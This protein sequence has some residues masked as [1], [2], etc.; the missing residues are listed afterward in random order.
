[1]RIVIISRWFAERMGY[2]E[3]C[4]PKALAAQGCDVHLV[5]ANVKPYFN[6][7]KYQEIYQRFLGDAIVPPDTRFLDGYTLY[8]QEHNVW[9]G[10]VGIKGLI[11]SL[12]SLR[13]HIV[14]TFDA[15]EYSTHKAALV[16][17]ISGYK[18]FLGS[19]LH[20]SVLPPAFLAQKQKLP[21]KRQI[22]S[23]T[24]GSILNAATERCYA[25]SA[26]A[27]DIV[28]AFSGLAPQKIEISPLGVDTDTF[29]PAETAE[30]K[31]LRASMRERFKFSDSEI[32]CIYTGRFSHDKDPLCLAKAINI[33]SGQGY[34]F[35][36]LFIGDGSQT[37][38]E[39]IQRCQGCVIH[40][41]VP[42]H[43]LPPFYW[44]SDI[45]VWP[46][47]ESTSQLDALACGLP[48][49]LSDRIHVHERIEGNGLTYKEDSSQ[50]LTEKLLQLKHLK[51][52]EN[53]GR[54]GIEKIRTQ[55]SWERIARQRIRDYET[56]LG[57]DT[58][59]KKIQH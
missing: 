30:E 43:E 2:A 51:L 8:R 50:D 1:M 39:A 48:L 45:G 54:V 21:L 5:T 27:A 32:V 46:K 23:A 17:Y 4:L 36:G 3:N 59:W 12:R 6:T 37:D 22:Y 15:F 26:D 57:G 14:Q 11:H 29:H 34:P 47:Q 42:F 38:I 40:P 31:E 13:P 9:R 20:A 10:Q 53:L 33:L 7:A 25:I 49:I 52:R 58:E 44:A 18:L 41:F 35:R 56:A 19:H 16:K 24:L 55:F 28:A